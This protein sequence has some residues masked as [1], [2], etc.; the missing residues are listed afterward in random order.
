MSLQRIRRGS[1]VAIAALAVVTALWV[2]RQNAS[3]ADQTVGSVSYVQGTAQRARGGT[4]SWNAVK[5]RSTVYQGDRLK[6]G[7]SA[8]LEAT[9]TD[10]S[11]LRLAA[12]SELSLD[13]VDVS[14]KKAKTVK[15]K[16]VIGQLWASVT[17]LFGSDS[18][19]EV[20]T[21]NAV[22]GVR[23]TRFAAAKDA[24]GKTT[25]KVYS[26]QVLVSNQ[27]I[28]AVKGH[29]KANRVEVS[30]P[31]EVTKDQWEEL[32]AGAMQVVTVAA[33][34]EMTPAQSFALADSKAGDDWEAWNSER[35]KVAAI[36]E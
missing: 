36:N 30:G 17:K 12:N 11:K 8:R 4:A 18:K 32:V 19:F 24:E 15:A 16:L 13:K 28:Y 29:T 7:D 20:T 34:G 25:V 2:C 10:G 31:Q 6:T 9:L 26:G 3:A 27:P 1:V 35:D 21:D 33:N 23:G 22:A 5:E 14:K